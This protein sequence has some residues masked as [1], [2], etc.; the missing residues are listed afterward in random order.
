MQTQK[1]KL[2]ADEDDFSTSPSFSAAMK[3][4]QAA[5]PAFP[6]DGGTPAPSPRVARGWTHQNQP[7]TA[8]SSTIERNLS[9]TTLVRQL[10]RGRRRAR[11]VER[12]NE[13]L[14]ARVNELESGDVLRA[15]Q[16]KLVERDEASA[17]RITHAQ[18]A[19][20]RQRNMPRTPRCDCSEHSFLRC[21]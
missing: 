6:K 11:T 13:V 9:Y 15:T 20:M 14:G 16:S 2:S 12:E 4:Q 17:K 7:T 5:P 21:P 19:V 18:S 8:R 1:N 10:D 3:S